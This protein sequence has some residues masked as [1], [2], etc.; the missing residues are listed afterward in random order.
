MQ[1]KKAFSI[2]YRAPGCRSLEL[3]FGMTAEQ[4]EVRQVQ[5]QR[6]C[7][8]RTAC[9]INHVQL[10]SLRRRIPQLRH[11]MVISIKRHRSRH[12]YNALAAICANIPGCCGALVC[13]ATGGAAA[14]ARGALP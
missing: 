5:R 13:A 14:G 6:D 11:G 3:D 4:Q 12:Q 2:A 8:H 9:S 1:Q 10:W 7:C